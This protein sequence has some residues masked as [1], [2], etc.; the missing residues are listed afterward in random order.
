VYANANAHRAYMIMDEFA[1][2][3]D[4]EKRLSFPISPMC[5]RYARLPE[6]FQCMHQWDM[7]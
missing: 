1:Q 2:Q 7:S 5:D 3:G 4:T 6:T